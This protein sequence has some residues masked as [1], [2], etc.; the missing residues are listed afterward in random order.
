MHS[1]FKAFTGMIH[2]SSS[3]PSCPCPS[4]ICLLWSCFSSHEC[5]SHSEVIRG[6]V[7]SSTLDKLED[8][9]LGVMLLSTAQKVSSSIPSAK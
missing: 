4:Y 2:M 9:D 7:C 8:C 5:S 1:R 6:P 3:F